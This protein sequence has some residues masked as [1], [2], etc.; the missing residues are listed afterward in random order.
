M[1]KEILVTSQCSLHLLENYGMLSFLSA[2]YFLFL[3]DCHLSFYSSYD[4]VWFFSECCF[5]C[6]VC[7]FPPSVHPALLPTPV[8]PTTSPLHTAIRLQQSS[9]IWTLCGAMA[10]QAM[11]LRMFPLT[12][13][14]T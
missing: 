4:L 3:A 14:V 6:F 8:A 7:R 13:Y 11:S 12:T 5:V 1:W 10:Q 9:T 2:C